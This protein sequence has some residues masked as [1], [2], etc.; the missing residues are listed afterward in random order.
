METK[1]QKTRG[2]CTQELHNLVTNADLN[3][4]IWWIYVNREDRAKYI[5][6][7]NDY[8]LFFVTSKSA[9]FA[10]VIGDLCAL[11]ET[12]DDTVNV[13]RTL[14]MFPPEVAERVRSNLDEAVPIW[15]KI[16][17]IGKNIFHH[18]NLGLDSD[19]VL[20]QVRLTPDGI[21]RLIEVSKEIV[22]TLSYA[23]DRSSF[24]FNLDPSKTTYRLL[25]W[26][27]EKRSLL[28]RGEQPQ[29]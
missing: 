25:N 16:Y 17:R 26:L 11:Y 10:A 9:H 4:R 15:K 1:V 7:L 12:R 27:S 3:F 13:N 28:A 24:A 18:R 22:N 20:A 21:K 8:S 2:E 6:T 19:A 5:N 14:K 29:L 23:H